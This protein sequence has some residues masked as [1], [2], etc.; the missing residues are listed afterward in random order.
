MEQKYLVKTI[1]DDP[2]KYF[3]KEVLNKIDEHAKRKFSYG[4][5]EE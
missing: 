2:E 1:N 3:T 4:T 5:E